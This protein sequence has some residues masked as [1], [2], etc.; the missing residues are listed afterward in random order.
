MHFNSGSI[1]P[2]PFDTDYCRACHDYGRTGSG[3]G[4]A[5]TGGTSTSGWAGYGA[6][7]ISARVH[8]VHFGAYLNR[9]ENVYE[10]IRM[11]SAE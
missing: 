5:R 11:P 2:Q 10:A 6:K 9:P 8:G 7:P 1:H 3:E 4:Y